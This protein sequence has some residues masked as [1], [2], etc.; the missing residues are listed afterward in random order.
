MRQL[1][2]ARNDAMW[3]CF[4]LNRSG[5]TCVFLGKFIDARAYFEKYLSLWDPM[6]RALWPAPED[7]YVASL[8]DLSR[9][10]LCLGY[11]D[12]ARL[13]RNEAL[14]EA[15][16]LLPYALAHGLSMPG[17]AIGGSKERNRQR[18]LFDR[19]KRHWPSRTSRASPISSHGGP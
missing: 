11:V 3:K 1:G 17:P 2:E 6:Y 19:R 7:L 10:L 15:R 14:V 4:G 12:Q 16:R 8:G 9:A 18:R 13:R 5:T